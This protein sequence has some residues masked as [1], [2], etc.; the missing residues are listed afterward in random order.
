MKEE[1]FDT[2]I[3][4]ELFDSDLDDIGWEPETIEDDFD[5]LESIFEY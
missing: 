4:S 1:E 5:E 2:V 3:N